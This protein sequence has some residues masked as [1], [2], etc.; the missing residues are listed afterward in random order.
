MVGPLERLAAVKWGDLQHWKMQ[1]LDYVWYMIQ[2][3]FLVVVLATIVLLI[4]DATMVIRRAFSYIE[5]YVKALMTLSFT[6]HLAL[7]GIEVKIALVKSAGMS[8]VQGTICRFERAAEMLGGDWCP[9]AERP[10]C[11]DL[12]CRVAAAHRMLGAALRY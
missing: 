10:S 4:V 11:D 7:A 12:S 3:G 9:V 6:K 2:I 5:T 1:Q 8:A